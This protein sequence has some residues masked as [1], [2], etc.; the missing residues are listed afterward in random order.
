MQGFFLL[1]MYT[2]VCLSPDEGWLHKAVKIRD[3]VHIIEEVQI[4]QEKQP[5]NNLVISQK[6]VT[7]NA[8]HTIANVM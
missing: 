5:I 6:Q 7:H 8:P 2:N 1:K 4:F 3:I